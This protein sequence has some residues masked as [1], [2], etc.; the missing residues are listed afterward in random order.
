MRENFPHLSGRIEAIYG[1]G[2]YAPRAYDQRMGALFDR[3]RRK[4][5]L[6]ISHEP[7]GP[8]PPRNDHEQLSLKLTS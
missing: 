6:P 1:R 2:A 4:Y 5:E 3:L 7:D 8:P